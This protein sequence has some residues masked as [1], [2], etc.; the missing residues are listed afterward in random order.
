MRTRTPSANSLDERR[1]LLLRDRLERPGRHV[2]DPQAGLDA[3]DRGQVGRPGTGEDVALDARTRQRARE[4]AHVDVHPAAVARAWLGERG[5]VKREHTETAHRSASLLGGP[6][7]GAP[8]GLR[9]H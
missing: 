7:K 9:G 6:S 4:L 5:S 1:E 8:L 3:D 2:V